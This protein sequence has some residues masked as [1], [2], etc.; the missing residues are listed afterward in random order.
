MISFTVKRSEWGRGINASESYLLNSETNKMCCL[1]FFGLQV[2]NLEKKDIL[3]KKTLCT[4]PIYL[5]DNVPAGFI[6]GPLLPTK[7]A[8][9]IMMVNDCKLNT[10]YMLESKG[11][12]EIIIETEEQREALLK[13]LFAEIGYEIEF[14]D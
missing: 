14:I 11:L 7:I 8:E 1:G 5:H 4:L 2:C 13:E 10:I 3:N 9:D 12:K 6:K